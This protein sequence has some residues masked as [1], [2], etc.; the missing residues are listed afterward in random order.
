[1]RKKGKD[2]L[3]VCFPRDGLCKNPFGS[4][5]EESKTPK[6]KC[7][8][9]GCTSGRYGTPMIIQLNDNS[10]LRFHLADHIREKGMWC[11]NRG[12]YTLTFV[13]VLDVKLRLL[14]CLV[15]VMDAKEANF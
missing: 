2:V 6:I 11:L 13:C 14:V 15:N 5:L 1:M 12:Y 9:D 8:Y 7:P 4:G 10:R 3:I